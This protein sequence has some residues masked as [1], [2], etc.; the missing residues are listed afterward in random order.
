LIA[1]AASRA[2]IRLALRL[3]RQDALNRARLNAVLSTDPADGGAVRIEIDSTSRRVLRH[4]LDYRNGK[5]SFMRV[6]S[7]WEGDARGQP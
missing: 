6:V 3:A 7:D 2:A 1:S 4:P 5:E